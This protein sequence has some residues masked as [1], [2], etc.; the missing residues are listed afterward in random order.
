VIVIPII[1]TTIIIIIIIRVIIIKIIII[2]LILLLPKFFADFKF[3]SIWSCIFMKPIIFCSRLVDV[4]SCCFVFLVVLCLLAML[5]MYLDKKLMGGYA[6]VVGCCCCCLF[7]LL[8]IVF[9][10][11]SSFQTTTFYCFV[12]C[13]LFV[14]CCV[15]HVSGSPSS[16]M[17][18]PLLACDRN[19][20]R[21]VLLLSLFVYGEC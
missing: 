4:V 18:Y 6:S 10:Y 1:T 7:V 3:S 16:T 11:R 21:F 9:L 12:L 17:L 15:D 2:I 8:G 5:L 14:L 20:P 13:W 19:V